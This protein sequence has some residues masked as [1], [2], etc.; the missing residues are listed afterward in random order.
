VPNAAL[1]FTPPGQ[2]SQP[3]AGAGV[4]VI[5]GDSLRRIGVHTG[6]SDGEFTAVTSGPLTPGTVV[7]TGLTPQGR[8][9][10]GT[11]H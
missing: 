11:G 8:A 7:V 5:A 10:F 9:A 3:G 1:A 6:I 2:T 4:W